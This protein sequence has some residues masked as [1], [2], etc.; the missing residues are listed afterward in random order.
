MKKA[1]ILIFIICG[2]FGITKG[3]AQGGPDQTF[4]NAGVGLSS[5]GIPI[6]VNY[7]TPI[8]VD[9]VTIS[10]GGSF[11]SKTESFNY[12]FNDRIRYRH[13]IIGFQVAGNYYF[14]ELLG[15]SNELDVYGG[16][17]LDYY[18]WNTRVLD[19]KFNTVEYSGGGAGGLGV[20]G[21]VGG[22]YHINPDKLSINLIVGAGTV[23]SSMRAGVSFWL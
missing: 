22:R 5:W 1:I 12:F 6:Y 9:N 3:V 23:F 2:G 16:L 11:Q 20:S 14:D 15:L 4:L 19:T 7:E 21:F 18:I 13:S 10:A 8:N 17:Q